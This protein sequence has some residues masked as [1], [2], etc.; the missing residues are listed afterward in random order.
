MFAC[1]SWFFPWSWRYFHHYFKTISCFYPDERNLLPSYCYEGLLYWTLWKREKRHDVHLLQW[2]MFMPIHGL[3]WYDWIEWQVC[4]VLPW[5]DR[6]C[7][8]MN[9]WHSQGSVSWCINQ[10]QWGSSFLWTFSFRFI[11]WRWDF[12]TQIIYFF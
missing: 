1:A 3:V 5:M 10:L 4:I 2:M 6:V 11:I 12:V 7:F 8:L 9:I